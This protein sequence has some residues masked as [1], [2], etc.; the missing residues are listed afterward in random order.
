MVVL[1]MK[2]TKVRKM[3]M[4]EI[5]VMEVGK[6]VMIQNFRRATRAPSPRGHL[7]LLCNMDRQGMPMPALGLGQD[8]RVCWGTARKSTET[9]P[10]ALPPNWLFLFRAWLLVVKVPQLCLHYLSCWCPGQ[11]AEWG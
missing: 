11:E 2:M 5:T 8:T 4:K 6:T 10:P 3:V 7:P 1:E 9:L